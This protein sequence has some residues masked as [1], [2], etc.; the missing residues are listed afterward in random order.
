MHARPPD[1]APRAA[2]LGAVVC[3][4]LLAATPLQAQ[5]T[6]PPSRGQLLYATHCV[7]CHD[8]QKHWRDNR[9]VRDWAGLVGQVRQWQGAQRLQ[10]NEADIVEVARHLN[11]RFYKLPQPGVR[12]GQRPAVAGAIG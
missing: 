4:T 1:P 11:D 6:S 7:A 3:A 9:L 10:W 12:Q 5:T 2:T 8:T